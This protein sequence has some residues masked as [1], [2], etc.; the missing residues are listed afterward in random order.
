MFDRLSPPWQQLQTLETSG[1]VKPGDTR[2]IELLF[3]PASV[4]W[5]AVHEEYREG[6]LFTDRLVRGPFRR[7]R[8]QHR[9]I[10]EG[11]EA[12]RIRDEIEFELPLS[13]VSHPLG[14]GIARMEL[15]RMFRY[16]HAV[17]FFD[18][19]EHYRL[20]DYARRNVRV[21]GGPEPVVEQLKAFLDI[22]GHE[23]DEG[24]HDGR[25]DTVVVSGDYSAGLRAEIARADAAN[26]GGIILTSARIVAPDA[27][28]LRL[29]R[30]CQF[31]ELEQASLGGRAFAW[32]TADDFIVAIQRL[33]LEPARTE[34]VRLQHPE[35]T[36]FA[37][38]V[39]ALGSDEDRMTAG[40]V[41]Q[42]LIDRVEDELAKDAGVDSKEQLERSRYRSLGDAIATLTGSV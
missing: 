11:D 7:W 26:D 41:P 28:L 20:R 37:D 21:S 16:R 19:V 5:L 40:A 39:R 18:F 15:R 27:P 1:S 3:G 23:V 10:D 13:F 9:F 30:A 25:S 36:T 24:E 2:E 29:A 8:H 34:V 14:L 31:F 33:L 38:L 12:C 32:S 17:T 42:P 22:A 4:R 6:H 35:S